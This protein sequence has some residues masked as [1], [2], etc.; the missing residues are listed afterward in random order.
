[1]VALRNL[2][3]HRG[4]A[5]IFLVGLVAGLAVCLLL[6]PCV[7]DGLGFDQWQPDPGRSYRAQM[8][9]R[10]PIAFAGGVPQSLARLR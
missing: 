10:Q 3:R 2:S 5:L 6:I 4:N 8:I 7:R 9:L 1:M